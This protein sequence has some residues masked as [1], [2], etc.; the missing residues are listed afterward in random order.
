M[1]LIPI[2]EHNKRMNFQLLLRTVGESDHLLSTFGSSD[3]HDGTFLQ[4]LAPRIRVQCEDRPHLS[5]TIGWHT[6]HKIQGLS[7]IKPTA[8]LLAGHQWRD[9]I[10]QHGFEHILAVVL[11]GVNRCDPHI[12]ERLTIVFQPAG[13]VLGHANVSEAPWHG[14]VVLAEPVPPTVHA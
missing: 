2:G 9:A 7:L 10:H 11:I 8:D 5:P 13:S 3:G 12:P 14:I 1:R 4:E 6:S